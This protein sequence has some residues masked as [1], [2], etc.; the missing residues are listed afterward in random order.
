MDWN[1]M[2]D[3][4]LWSHRLSG[5]DFYGFYYKFSIII[6]PPEAEWIVIT[7]TIDFELL[8]P[9]LKRVGFLWLLF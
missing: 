4:Q 8:S 5:F 3:S 7:F 9:C 2:A 6:T 1:F